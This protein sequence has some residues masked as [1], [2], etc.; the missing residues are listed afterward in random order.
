MIEDAETTDGRAAAFLAFA[1]TTRI[2]AG[3]LA[4]VAL[5]AKRALEGDDSL[6][7]LVF[8]ADTGAVVDLDLRGTE[9][10]VLAK[11]APPRDVSSKRG[12]PKLGVVAREITLLPRHWEWLSS[13]PGGASVALRK[14]VEAARK[15]DGDAGAVRARA[16]AAYRF[17]SAMAGD[18]PGFEDAAR[19]VFAGVGDRLRRDIADWPQDIRDQALSYLRIDGDETH[20]D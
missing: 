2:A 14:L 9:A 4:D 10:E 16:E 11:Y 6:S 5:E 17:M 8:D 19:S 3:T 15:A 12:R 20:H 13:Q 7:V 18:L 1:G